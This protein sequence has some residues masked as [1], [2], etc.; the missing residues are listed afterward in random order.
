MA[1]PRRA[2]R[3]AH[4]QTEIRGGI[5]GPF[6][7]RSRNANRVEVAQSAFPRRPDRRSPSPMDA[8]GAGLS[9]RVTCACPLRSCDDLTVSTA[10]RRVS[11]SKPCCPGASAS[12]R[13]ATVPEGMTGRSLAAHRR[14]ASAKHQDE[15]RPGRRFGDRR[16]RR[17]RGW[18]WRDA[19]DEGDLQIVV[20]VAV[21]IRFKQLAGL[22]DIGS[23]TAATAV[24]I[25]GAIVELLQEVTGAT[26]AVAATPA[27]RI[28]I[29]APAVANGRDTR[30]R[31][32]VV[33]CDLKI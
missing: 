19:L 27:A 14:P 17:R 33:L 16:C 10:C 8:N 31:V 4:E 23:A 20:A 24:I 21:V 26:A 32:V 22:R 18:W 15:H 5:P 3:R 13:G 25:V 6:H 9:H 2:P 7:R 12:R 30:S 29:A 11:Q 1:W 28:R